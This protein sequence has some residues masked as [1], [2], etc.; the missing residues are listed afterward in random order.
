LL[1]R[2]WVVGVEARTK[3]NNLAFSREDA[4]A[5]AFA[6][7]FFNKHLSATL[8]FVALGDIA[9]KRDQNGVY[10]SLQTGF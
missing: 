3:P 9:T 6:A 8:A 1:S 4:A 7:Y 5:D 2:N 10:L